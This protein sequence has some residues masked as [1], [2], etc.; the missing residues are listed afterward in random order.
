MA[1]ITIDELHLFHQIDREVFCFLVFKLHRDLTQSLLVMALWLWLENIGNSN[2]VRKIMGL[3]NAL[4]NA[5]VD[6]AVVC[7]K[8]LEIDNPLI[9]NGGG[10]PLTQKLTQKDISLRIFNKKRYTTIAGI[11]SVL[12]NICARVFNDVVEIVLKSSKIS[13]ASTSYMPLVVPGFPHPLFGAF[14]VPPK[15]MN[16]DLSDNTIWDGKQPYNDVTDDDRS[17]FLTFSRGFPVSE[18]E[19]RVLFTRI[20][21]DCILS[22]TMG[23]VDENDQHLFAIMILQMVET[24]DQI[25]NGKRVA[26]LYINGKHIW[27]RKYERRD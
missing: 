1:P 13:Q 23:T 21:G 3:P 14:D 10:L 8:C 9:P 26:K 4:V 24:V 20:Y 22:L 12:Q 25:L 18:Q 27:A 15:T 19:V 17:M 16:L 7:L 5:L 6:E 11:K 2:V